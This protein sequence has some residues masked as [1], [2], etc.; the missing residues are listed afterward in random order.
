MRH[1]VTREL[2]KRFTSEKLSSVVV[3]KNKLR[4]IVIAK[5]KIVTVIFK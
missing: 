4:V 5:N 1:S 3:T 2:E